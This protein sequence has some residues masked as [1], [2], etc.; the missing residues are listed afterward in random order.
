M[1]RLIN[2]IQLRLSFLLA[3]YAK[4]NVPWGSPFAISIE[5]TTSC[6]LRCPQCPSGLRSFS[7]ATGMIDPETNRLI[8]DQLGASLA[9]IT[10]Y[11]QGEPLLHP[12]FSEMV[13]YASR[14]RIFTQT[15]TNAHHLNVVNCEKLIKSGLS[16]LIISIDGASQA[17]YEKYRIGGSLDKV[18]LGTRTLVESKKTLKSQYPKVIWQFI[19]FNHN[20]NEIEEVKKLALEVGV[21]EIQIKSAQI[22]DFEEGNEMIPE[23][24]E[25][26]RYIQ[27]SDGY[28]ISSDLPNHCW[29]MWQGCVFTW[30]GNVV[31]CCFDKDAK[32][33]MG[34]IHEQHFSEIWKSTS[35][36]QFRQQLS[37]KRK[38]I[39]ICTNCSEGL[40][41]PVKNRVFENVKT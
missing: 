31:P 13:A 22:Y 20:K 14:K 15:S 8:I 9:Y 37:I 29:R 40:K 30:D 26:S 17:T 32:H 10:Y 33:V 28:R 25:F 3:R 36:R 24:H 11:F 38:N 2:L 16:S 4:L 27:T 21:D 34:N 19:V 6:N 35:Y 1:P 39:D 23:G 7:R 5:P 12:H 18:I 41:T